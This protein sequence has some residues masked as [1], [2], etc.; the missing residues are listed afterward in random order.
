MVPAGPRQWHCPGMPPSDFATVA[1]L[2]LLLPVSGTLAW[3]ITLTAHPSPGG[4]SVLS[5]GLPGE[6]VEPGCTLMCC[7]L[8]EPEFSPLLKEISEREGAK[9]AV[10]VLRGAVLSSRGH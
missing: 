6:T 7:A 9:E 1:C 2:G 8:S 3:P 4:T 5:N 10:E